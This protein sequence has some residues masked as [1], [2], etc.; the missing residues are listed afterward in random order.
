V[1]LR[2]Y[3]EILRRWFWLP[4]LLALVA[5]GLSIALAPKAQTVYTST[6]RVFVS[7]PTEQATPDKFTF[8]GY[9]A[10]VASEYFVDDL[11]EIVKTQRFAAEV[12]RAINDPN[13]GAA[14]ITGTKSTKRTHRLLDVTVSSADPELIAKISKASA[15]VLR[16]RAIPLIRQIG[17]GDPAPTIEVLEE[18]AVT[19]VVIGLRGNLDIIVRAAL[20]GVAGVALALLL[21]YLD[22]SI[23]SKHDAE[24]SLGLSVIGEIP[25]GKGRGL[26]A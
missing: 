23:R 22:T 5:G 21:H 9:Y 3:V 19:P 6:L 25:S 14:A 17:V 26:F 4:V 1:E 2:Q 7:V 18:G 11:A 10:W 15:E 12:A 16:T 13:V 8:S 20:G 24:D